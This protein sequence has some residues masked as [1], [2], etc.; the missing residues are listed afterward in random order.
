MISTAL[1]CVHRLILSPVGDAHLIY[2]TRGS[3][4]AWAMTALRGYK[5]HRVNRPNLAQ[6][7]DVNTLDNLLSRATTPTSALVPILKNATYL[8]PRQTTS[9][10]ERLPRMAMLHQHRCTG[11]GVSAAYSRGGAWSV[12]EREAYVA[13]MGVLGRRLVEV[14]ADCTPNQ[15]RRAFWGL[16]MME[17]SSG[18]AW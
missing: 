8:N 15:L 1:E 10:L 12:G 14:L 5:A 13:L 17:L 4:Y 3:F 18:I 6:P 11:G 2:R 9:M 7:I 16:A